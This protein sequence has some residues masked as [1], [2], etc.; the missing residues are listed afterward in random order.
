MKYLKK[1]NDNLENDIEDDL[2]E[3]EGLIEDCFIDIF[4]EYKLDFTIKIN[5]IVNS[6]D[7]TKSTK[8]FIVEIITKEIRDKRKINN[9]EGWLQ[10]IPLFKSEYVLNKAKN[11]ILNAINRFN[12]LSPK[13]DISN[14][15]PINK[16]YDHIRLT[17]FKK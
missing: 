12:K 8:Y 2:M 6:K 17:I 1:I 9:W 15:G 3:V 13:Y 7:L 4:D 11:K 10:N 14:L 5:E 16:N